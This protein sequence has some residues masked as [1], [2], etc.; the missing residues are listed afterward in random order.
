MRSK[1]PLV[2]SFSELKQISTMLPV[3]IDLPQHILD[4]IGKILSLHAYMEWRLSLV[5]YSLLDID[6]PEGR[7]A[8]AYHA[9]LSR[10]KVIQSLFEWNGAP[11]NLKTIIKSIQEVGVVRDHLPM[12]Y[13]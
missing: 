1:K 13:G 4:G 12:A 8:W 10:A 2:L 11:T 3:V 9:P 7:I 6:L 5:I